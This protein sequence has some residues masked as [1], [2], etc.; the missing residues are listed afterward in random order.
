VDL[1]GLLTTNAHCNL[2]V[3]RTP[4]EFGFLASG[5]FVIF[6]YLLGCVASSN[7]GI[8]EILILVAPA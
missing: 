3:L 6:T 1:R 5:G 8:Y 4:W 7:F 2:L